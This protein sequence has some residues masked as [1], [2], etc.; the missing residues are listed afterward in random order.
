MKSIFFIIFLFTFSITFSQ[1][2]SKN[3][4]IIY[5]DEVIVNANNTNFSNIK[6]I[7][8]K[9]KQNI[10]FSMRNKGII[11]SLVENIPQG[12]INTLSFYFNNNKKRTYKDVEFRLIIYSVDI[13]NMPEKE[14]FN[15]DF[16]FIVK[17]ID[18]GKISLDLR[19]LNLKNYDKLFIGL[20]LL[21]NRD[22]QDFLIDCNSVKNNN[23]FI[24]MEGMENWLKKQGSDLKTE[25]IFEIK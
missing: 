17:N 12:N 16:R 10:S 11:I 15:D 4:S 23:T 25:I 19:K 24:K 9:G 13:N 1:S 2:S 7:L 21:K 14:V 8:T 5:L 3:D 18:K 6:T 22:S 20:E